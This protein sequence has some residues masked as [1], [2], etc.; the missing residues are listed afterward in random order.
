MRPLDV[1]FTLN[2]FSNLTG[3]EICTY[4]LAREL[5]SRGH[6]VSVCAAM[7]PGSILG[8]KAR[9]AGI[10]LIGNNDW[11]DVKVDPD[12]VHAAQPAPTVWAIRTFKRARIISHIHGFF[13]HERPV[14]SDSIATYLAALPEIRERCISHWK[15]PE[16]KVELLWNGFD[17]TRFHPRPQGATSE[18]TV[19][20]AG[21]IDQFR[22]QSIADLVRRGVE[23]GFRVRVVGR[24]LLPHWRD[25]MPRGVDV[26][27]SDP[28]WDMENCIHEA[29]EVAGLWLG[30]TILEGW[31]C[32]KMAH[33]YGF[34]E[35]GQVTWYERRGPPHAG[36]DNVNIRTVVS[37]LEGIYGR[38]LE[39]RHGSAIG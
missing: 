7:Q 14:H 31:L 22:I 28:V 11:G 4:E 10:R 16:E 30:R 1:L 27:Q 15:L 12:I 37:R 35:W 5:V 38:A 17:F 23:E 39:G 13:S 3:S 18:K 29:H 19:L 9:E 32:G 36:L 6:R 26:L 33:C 2:H 21:T 34:D 20:Y 8:A 24:V 25:L